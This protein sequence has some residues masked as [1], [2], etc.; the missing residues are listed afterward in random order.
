MFNIAKTRVR[1]R[2]MTR[3]RKSSKLR[4]PELP[5]ST[6]VV[7]PDAEA[8]PVGQHAVVAGPGVLHAGGGEDVHVVVDQT[9]G[10][11]QAADIDRSCAPSAGSMSG[12]TAAIFPSGHGDVHDRIDLVARIDDMSALE[13]D[14]VSRLGTGW[15]NDEKDDEQRERESDHEKQHGLILGN[16][17][18]SSASATGRRTAVEKRRVRL[19]DRLPAPRA[20]ARGT[21]PGRRDRGRPHA[22]PAASARESV[23]GRRRDP[24]GDAARSCP[25]P[26]SAR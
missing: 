1:A 26:A 3:L 11:V 12:R 16:R 4:H 7:T 13:H 9:G 22:P 23:R 25:R 5:A 6:I 21:S 18:R 14:L 17:I 2:S 10:D 8:E 15:R 24:S 19:P 20:R